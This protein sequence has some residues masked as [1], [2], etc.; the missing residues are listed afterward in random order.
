MKHKSELDFQ[1]WRFWVFSLL[2]LVVSGLFAFF[3]L[4]ANNNPNAK[5]VLLLVVVFFFCFCM[6]LYEFFRNYANLR[7]QL[8]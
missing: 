8:K 3:T 6:S 7:K 2:V 5:T 4:L 1:F